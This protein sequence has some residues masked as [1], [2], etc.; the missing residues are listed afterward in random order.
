[1]VSL[2]LVRLLTPDDYG[3]VALVTVL[4]GILDVFSTRGFNQAIIQKKE[5]DDLDYSTIFVANMGIESALYIVIFVTAPLI[6]K[7]YNN[8]E[9]IPLIRFISIRI[10]ITGFN[11]IQQAYVQRNMLYRKFFLS[12]L[13]GTIVSAFVGIGM[14]LK[15]YGV[16]ALAFQTVV[17]TFIDTFVLFLTINWR[18]RL[19]FSFVRLK[20]MMHFGINMFIMAIFESVYNELRSLVIGK[21]Y[22]SSDLAFYNKGKNI[23]E[24]L[25]NNIQIA[26]NNVFFSA[27][28]REKNYE[29]V[30]KKMREYMSIMFYILAPM[31]LGIA[32]VSKNLIQV[33]Y[34][35]KW[36]ET[37][38]YMILYC[39]IYL[40]WILQMPILQAINSR[41]RVD[42][43]LKLT[44]LHR[45]IGIGILIL[46]IRKGPVYIA[47]GAL[48]ADYVITIVD[49]LIAKKIFRYTL[50]E[51]GEDIGN[52]L[53]CIILS[54]GCVYM[55]G[56]MI[57][58]I[59]LSIILQV[60]VG[61]ITYIL[62]SFLFKNK[63][64]LIL[65]Q[66]LMQKLKRK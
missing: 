52:T 8:I 25:I 2:I 11:A 27:L 53:F 62:F 60:M 59:W 12:T 24:L 61:V 58:N 34:T 65:K 9:L 43:T 35:S 23:P 20:E 7:F 22:T 64:F 28:S 37:R 13:L 41:G 29:D 1:M 18:P 42:I 36:M 10:L 49:I 51:M 21:W 45:I 31:M 57:D 38:P 17:N 30:K 26:A 56:S 4:V 3:T 50:I 66:I 14:A 19:R 6:A 44:I 55:A 33:L 46:W 63:L 5:V 15:G 16:W 39:M 48:V 54:M 32:T 40:S 47:V